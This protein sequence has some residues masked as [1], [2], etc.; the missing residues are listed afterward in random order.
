GWI[1][2]KNP[3]PLETQARFRSS[4]PAKRPEVL[5]KQPLYLRVGGIG[6]GVPLGAVVTTPEIAKVMTSHGYL[7]TFGGNPVSTTAGLAVL[8]VIENE[9]LQQNALTVGTY[10]KNQLLNLKE[11]H[12][13]IGDVRGRGFLLGIELVTDRELKTPAP[14]ETLHVMEQM[15]DMG[16][17]IGKGGIHGNIFRISPALC[18]TKEDADFLVATMDY[19]IPIVDF[20]EALVSKTPG[21]LNVVFFTNSG[22]EANELALLI[23]R[24]YTGSH[25][26]ISLRNGYHGNASATMAAT[27]QRNHKYNVVQTGIHHALNPDPYRGIHGSDGPKY[28]K[29]VDEII[30]YGTSGRIA[31]FISEAI[32]G[33]GGI[34]E[35]GLIGKTPLLW[36]H[37]R[38]FDPHS[39]QKG[40]MS[41]GSSLS[42]FG[43]GYLNTF[44]G[45]PV[46]TTAGLAV[47]KVIENENLQQNAL[48]VGTYLKNQL[49][50]LKEKHEIIDMG[51]L[52]G[53]GGI[54]GNIFRISP[55]LCFTKEDAGY[56]SVITTALAEACVVARMAKLVEEAQ[57]NKS[58]TQR[59]VDKIAKYYTP[60]VCVVAACLAAIPAALRVHNVDKWYH[61]ALVV[62]VSA[63][64]CALILSTPIAA[65]CAFSKAATSGLLFKGAEYLEILSTVK[66]I[67]FDKTG[68]ITQGEFSVSNFDPLV[69]DGKLL[70]W[71][72]SIESKSSHPMAAALVD[73]AKSHSFE[74]Q[75]DNVEEF[76]DFPGEGIYG[77]I[78][79]KDVYIGNQ[80]IAVRAGCSQVL[81]YG[82]EN[83]DGK[84]VGY[85]FLGST[86]AGTF[87]LSDS[88][89]IGVKEALEELKSMGIK[90][91]ML[92][93]DCQ[94]AA[95]YAQNQLGGAFD[96]VHA[97]LLPQDKA[98]IIKEIQKESKTAMVGDGLN[99]APALATADIGISMGVSGSALANETGHVILMSNDIRKI[100]VAVRLARKTRR[101]I[102]ENIFIAFVTKAAVIA[103]AIAGH[104]LVWAAVLA[105][106]GTCLLVIFNSMLLLQG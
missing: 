68:T 25:D 75:S 14:L 65:Y 70:Y 40:R 49:L 21:D 62:L 96:V 5:W 60:A 23:A 8:K 100:P 64:P 57:N 104:P 38:G 3:S 67:C 53:K 105:D 50:D 34:Y 66:F 80:K 51:V 97:E 18:F 77:K 24:L 55:A 13:I 82:T 1:D 39:L 99:D 86:L 7:N 78:D 43:H 63:C 69:K 90:T 9:N 33:V 32:Q 73:Y 84:S 17:L 106:V 44:G 95:N 61:L 20:A 26:I 15:R 46:S 59:Y 76:K 27:A 12:E 58:K 92:T 16:V 71:V 42:T 29:D 102:F 79:G 28:A 31:G 83:G 94:A 11:K 85:I 47:L 72:S 37:G 93:G 89:R 48:T 45:N 22:T 35:V 56:I 2:W 10:L 88:C 74:P 54:H 6:N 87:S 52:I 81:R 101:K 98:K 41:S 36:R 4:L 19:I 103:L 30:M 91:A